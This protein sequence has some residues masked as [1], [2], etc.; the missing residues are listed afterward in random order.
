MW[1]GGSEDIAEVDG[2]AAWAEVRGSAGGAAL[3]GPS[4]CAWPLV[5]SRFLGGWTLAAA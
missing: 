1:A 4:A 2:C 5:R 3:D